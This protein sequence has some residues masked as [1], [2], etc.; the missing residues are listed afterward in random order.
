MN[1]QDFFIEKFIEKNGEWSKCETPEEKQMWLA[2]FGYFVDG[3]DCC[4][5]YILE[6][7]NRPSDDIDP[8]VDKGG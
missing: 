8:G 3:W 1:E 6:Q 7:F 2:N 4:K 5:R